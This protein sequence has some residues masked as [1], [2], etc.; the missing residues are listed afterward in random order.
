[1]GTPEFAVP[2]LEGILSKYKVRAVVTQPDKVGNRGELSIPPVKNSFRSYN[3][4][5][6]TGKFKR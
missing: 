4:S 3:F 5:F 6:T 1:M 2:I